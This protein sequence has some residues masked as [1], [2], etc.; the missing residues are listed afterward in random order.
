MIEYYVIK[1][2][3]SGLYIDYTF[4]LDIFKNCREFPSE[5][6]AY[7]WMYS[8]LAPGH[9]TVIKCYRKLS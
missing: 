2:I 8:D 7:N 4:K 3:G 9:Y 1:D 5:A 6:E